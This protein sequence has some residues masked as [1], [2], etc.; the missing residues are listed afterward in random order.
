[1]NSIGIA[2][3]HTIKDS[4]KKKLEDST[5]HEEESKALTEDIISEFHLNVWKP[6]TH[7]C[8]LHEIFA[9]DFGLM[10][11]KK[12]N[13]IY[14]YFPFQLEDYQTDP[15][16]KKK[17]RWAD[18][19]EGMSKNNDLICTIFNEELQTIK[20]PNTCYYKVSSVSAGNEGNEKDRS[21]FLYTLAD[22]NIEF[23]KE[24]EVGTLMNIKIFDINLLQAAANTSTPD[25]IYIRFRIFVKADNIRIRRN[26]SN[27]L[28]QAAFSKMDLYDFKINETMNLDWKIREKFRETGHQLTKFNKAHIF[29]VSSTKTTVQNGS[30]QK[31]DSRLIDPNKWKFYEPFNMHGNV[32]I[33][34]HWKFEKTKQIIKNKDNDFF[35]EKEVC[36]FKDVKLFCTAQYPQ[37]QFL[38]LIVYFLLIIL[39][40]AAGSFLVSTNRIAI[41]SSWWTI[42]TV[43]IALLLI[44]IWLCRAIRFKGGFWIEEL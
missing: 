22:T 33:S 8:T 34:H 21:F 32:Y 31:N 4:E 5:S 44:I 6:Q 12:Y 20:V 11:P 37:L 2:L 17:S 1:M 40:G 25:N 3:K 36:P 13:S 14:F 10:F 30:L 19:G 24:I 42:G 7:I 28:I 41:L 23:D 43:I 39:L 26:I 27:D 38:T 18:L 35:T 15:K 9:F 16:Q 29:Y